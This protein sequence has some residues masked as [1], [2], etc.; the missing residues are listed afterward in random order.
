[1]LSVAEIPSTGFTVE[2][3]E[4]KFLWF[5]D[6]SILDL[7]IW[8]IVKLLNFLLPATGDAVLSV[9]GTTLI[10]KIKSGQSELMS[11]EESFVFKNLVS[12]LA[13]NSVLFFLLPLILRAI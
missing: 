6:Q 8:D 10:Y 7:F 3:L 11:T 9:W 5:L 1:M 4:S 13:L 12:N 2:I